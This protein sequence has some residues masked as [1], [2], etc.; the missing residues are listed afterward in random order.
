MRTTENGLCS[1]I[2]ALESLLVL[3]GRTDTNIV[4]HVLIKSVTE[5]PLKGE[6]KEIWVDMQKT[7]VD[8]LRSVLYKNCRRSRTKQVLI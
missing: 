4:K 2:D 7:G 8:A 1:L 6:N 3:S 5:T